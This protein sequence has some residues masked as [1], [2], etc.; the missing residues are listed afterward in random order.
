MYKSYSYS[1]MPKAVNSPPPKPPQPEPSMPAPPPKGGKQS[2]LPM[3]ISP[4]KL[5]S[6]DILLLIVITALLLN[7][8]ED[9]LLLLALAYIFFS[10][11]FG[12]KG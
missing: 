6:D 1:N 5:Q 4:G 7:E 9:K 11:Y 3:G 8:C 12:D 10:D 2:G